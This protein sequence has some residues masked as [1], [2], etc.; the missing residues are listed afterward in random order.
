MLGGCLEQTA[1]TQRGIGNELS[2]YEMK[3]QMWAASPY[4]ANVSNCLSLSFSP[5]CYHR[6]CCGFKTKQQLNG[7]NCYYV[8]E[9][10]TPMLLK[11]IN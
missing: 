5:S 3:L 8:T 7:G 1:T 11:T 9:A 4:K 2:E 10:P 6:V